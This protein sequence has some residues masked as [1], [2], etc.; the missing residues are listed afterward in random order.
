MDALSILGIQAQGLV[1]AKLRMHEL[2]I[3]LDDVEPERR[4]K[5]F[6]PKFWPGDHFCGPITVSKQ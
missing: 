4:I 3:P 6:S 2:D 1:Q 5:R